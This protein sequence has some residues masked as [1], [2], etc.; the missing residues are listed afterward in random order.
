L[1]STDVAQQE[2]LQYLEQGCLNERDEMVRLVGSLNVNEQ[3]SL[4]P[5]LLRLINEQLDVMKKQQHI[6]QGNPTSLQ[7][8]YSQETRSPLEN[9][10]GSDI[11][12]NAYPRMPSG[13][14]TSVGDL[15]QSRLTQQQQ[16]QH[17]NV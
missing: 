3:N 2:L 8:R 5:I 10:F 11:Y 14:V 12:T 9:W 6:Q 13:R 7:H 16:Q 1:I 15:E 17:S 4:K